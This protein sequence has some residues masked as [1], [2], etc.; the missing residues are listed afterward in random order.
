[1]ELKDIAATQS[2]RDSFESAFSAQQFAPMLCRLPHIRQI[3]DTFFAESLHEFV[4]GH[5]FQAAVFEFGFP[6]QSGSHL[7]LEPQRSSSVVRTP[8]AGGPLGQRVDPE[9]T[10]V[11]APLV[12]GPFPIYRSRYSHD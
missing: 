5:G 11:I 4:I 10:H 9:F 1:M 6:A 12:H 8:G 2:L 7:A 3:L